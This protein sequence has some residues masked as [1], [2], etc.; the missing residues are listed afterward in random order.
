MSF[1]TFVTIGSKIIKILAMLYHHNVSQVIIN[2][3][4][5]S[6]ATSIDVNYILLRQT[7]ADCIIVV[8]LL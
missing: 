7:I 6:L 2:I 3:S 4:D 1:V 8:L 5:T